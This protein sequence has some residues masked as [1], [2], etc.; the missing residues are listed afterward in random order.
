MR[1]SV[2]QQKAH[3]GNDRSSFLAV[4]ALLAGAVVIVIGVTI[5]VEMLTQNEAKADALDRAVVVRSNASLA[6]VLDMKDDHSGPDHHSDHSFISKRLKNDTAEVDGKVDGKVAQRE[7]DAEG[8]RLLA[9]CKGAEASL[10][11]HQWKRYDCLC[12]GRC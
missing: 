5:C 7:K 4:M 11:S 3:L 1:P 2:A 12:H 6:K 9:W 10:S 8:R